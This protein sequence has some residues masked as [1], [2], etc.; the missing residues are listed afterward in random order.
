M[1][2]SINDPI[3]KMM[4]FSRCHSQL[5][6][7]II[8][9]LEF[10]RLRHIKQLGLVQLVFPGA[11]N[12]RF[13]HCIGASYMANLVSNQVGLNS[14][15]NDLAIVAALVHDIGHGPFSHMFERL[16]PQNKKVKHDV[17]WLGLFLDLLHRQGFLSDEHHQACKAIFL[18]KEKSS[19]FAIIAD[20]V[21]SQLD[22]DRLDYLL[23]D[24]YYCGVTYGKFNFK[25]L[26][27]C[28]QSV[29]VDGV[30]RLGVLRKGMSALEHYIM[31]RRLMT[32]NIYANGKINGARHYLQNFL[33]QLSE[34]ITEKHYS[35]I[36]STLLGKYCFLLYQYRN[37]EIDK[38]CFISQAFQYY[39][40][41]VDADIW[42][43]LRYIS[44]LPKL[45]CVTTLAQR[46]HQRQ[47]PHVFSIDLKD[48]DEY[49]KKIA[50]YLSS[51]PKV[52]SW[53]CHIEQLN[54]IAYEQHNNPIHIEGES[55]LFD[56][57]SKT[58]EPTCWLYV[59]KGI[60]EDF[61]FNVS[62]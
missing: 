25:W 44:E 53:Q 12:T 58:K 41:L 33:I 4:T 43:A 16:L 49:R 42:M 9:S 46:I 59:D 24:S 30:Q 60:L 11:V 48:Y 20:I 54:F 28:M 62:I 40:K 6:K 50:D 45:D 57:F 39:K 27:S 7:P 13:S 22:A 34:R 3:Y 51:R 29:N 47:L 1:T 2:Y 31:C 5:I 19:E 55:S 35:D 17:E 23:R 56:F 38:E 8:D 21:S 37:S 52:K 10:Q 14:D 32:K 61:L 15:L 36:S 18:H 26:L